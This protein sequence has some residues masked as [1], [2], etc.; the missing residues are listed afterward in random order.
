[1]GKIDDRKFLVRNLVKRGLE[2]LRSAEKLLEADLLADSI[3]R[4]YYSIYHH[5]TGLLLSLDIS[6]KTH[7][8]TQNL[9]YIHFVD[10]N[11]IEKSIHKDINHVMA[12]RADAD[13]G[14]ITNF[15]KDDAELAISTANRV[16][17]KINELLEDY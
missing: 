12:M 9:L 1:M 11:I 2:A 10:K 8:G 16:I 4:A 6:A 5:V 13:Y 3:S 7:R 17:T 15:T 14:A